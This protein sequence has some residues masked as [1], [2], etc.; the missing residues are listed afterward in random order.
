VYFRQTQQLLAKFGY[1]PTMGFVVQGRKTAKP[2][3]HPMPNL[4]D[5]P[6]TSNK[7]SL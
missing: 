2:N 6:A 7:P 1:I 4:Q 3:Q 5:T